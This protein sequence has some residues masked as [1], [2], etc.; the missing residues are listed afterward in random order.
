MGYDDNTFFFLTYLTYFDNMLLCSLLETV[1]LIELDG[2]YS[3]R[4]KYYAQ[5]LPF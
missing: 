4:L 3:I 2:C 5:F 1:V